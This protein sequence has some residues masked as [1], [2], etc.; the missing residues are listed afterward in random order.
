MPIASIHQ[1]DNVHRIGLGGETGSRSLALERKAPLPRDWLT[2]RAAS[3]GLL[4]S[5]LTLFEG[6]RM[7]RSPKKNT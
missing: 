1:S 7:L 3:I 4:I 2:Q 6:S 5:D